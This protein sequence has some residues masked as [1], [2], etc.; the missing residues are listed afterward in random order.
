MRDPLNSSYIAIDG[1]GTSCRFS[2]F[3][4]GK[5]V[6]VRRGSANVFSAPDAAMETLKSGLSELAEQAGIAVERLADIPLYAGLAGVTD[7][8]SAQIVANKL[9]CRN[10]KVE[11]DRPAAVVGALGARSGSL[12]GIGTGSFLA[13]QTGENIALLG[14]YG[15][16][17]GDQGSGGWLGKGLLCRA[18][19][20]LDGLE[21][22][23]DLIEDCLT[24]FQHDA[25]KIVRF[26]AA[27]QPAD[28][29]A[30]APQVVRAAKAGDPAGRILM[31]AGAN[32]ICKAL[33]ALGRVPGEP[34]CAIGGVA[35][36]YAD[37]L[38]PEVSADMVAPQGE[39][40]DGALELARRFARQI[41]QEEV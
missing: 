27:A 38:P 16:V 20:A 19:L 22:T 12:I 8:D 41:W 32:Y 28:Y 1:G 36:H 2:L 15:A 34:V 31:S 25:A 17:L 7:A 5:V 3:L 18:L 10:A 11:D 24:E 39:A 21:S 6:T 29:G 14:G 23:S 35:S 40:L 33:V 13:R 30:Y 9:P 26:T 37:F 4:L